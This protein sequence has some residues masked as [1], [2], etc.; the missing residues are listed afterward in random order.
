[1]PSIAPHRAKFVGRAF[2]SR[3][4]ALPGAPGHSLMHLTE[5]ALVETIK[6]IAARG[7]Q[8][9]LGPGD[10]CAIFR[11]KQSDDL[12][13]KVDPMIEDIHFL[14]SQS[15]AIVGQ[16]ALGRNLSDIAAMGGEPDFCLVSLAVPA[17]LGERWIKEFYRGLMILARQTKTALAGGHLARADKIYCDVIVCGH[18]PRGQALLRSGA[19]PGDS[20]YVSGKL[21]KPWDGRIVPRLA[22]GKS[23]R[24][25]ATSCMDVSDGLSLDLHRLC[26]ASKVAA[27]IDHVPARRGSSIERALNGGE[28]YELLF[29]LPPK[30]KPPTG[31]SRIGRIVE[32][33]PGLIKYQGRVLKALGHDH[34]NP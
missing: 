15:A 11:P 19:Q 24:G 13:F 23:L 16:R 22:L 20:L 18:V 3:R 6:R 25:R 9:T 12:L 14:R 21:G 30:M 17:K 7:P 32:G 28:D 4:R 2:E 10:D 33:K 1:M 5:L 27:E 8:I 26:L 34:F 29:S 31:T